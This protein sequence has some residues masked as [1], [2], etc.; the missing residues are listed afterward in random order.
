MRTRR[1][2]ARLWENATRQSAKKKPVSHLHP[3]FVL[4]FAVAVVRLLFGSVLFSLKLLFRFFFWGRLPEPVFFYFCFRFRFSFWDLRGVCSSMVVS[5][6]T[7]TESLHVPP[8]SAGDSWGLR[9]PYVWREKKVARD[10]GAPIALPQTTRR[11]WKLLG[12][13]FVTEFAGATISVFSSA[14]LC[15]VSCAGAA[16]MVVVTLFIQCASK[17][18]KQTKEPPAQQQKQLEEAE[19]RGPR[20]SVALAVACLASFVVSSQTQM[21]AWL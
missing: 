2:P 8:R 3:L 16:L 20:S 12:C 1:A 11:A 21:D 6:P 17:K 4:L 14:S 13:R 10:D 18:T 7:L 19:L 5:L 9:K 15:S